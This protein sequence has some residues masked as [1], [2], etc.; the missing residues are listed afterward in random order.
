LKPHTGQSIFVPETF[1]NK[2]MPWIIRIRQ[3][4]DSSD[5]GNSL[6]EELELLDAQVH[7]Q[8]GRARDVP[9]GMRKTPNEAQLDRVRRMHHDDRNYCRRAL[10]TEYGSGMGRDDYVNLDAR[11]SLRP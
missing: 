8:G 1:D 9:A 4:R 2:W 3:Y 11:P 7:T 6:L 5:P 10:G